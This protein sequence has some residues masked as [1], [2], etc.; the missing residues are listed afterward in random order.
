M[1]IQEPLHAYILS[2]FW[3]TQEPKDNPQN[4]E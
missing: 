2:I 4:L 3:Q 1:P